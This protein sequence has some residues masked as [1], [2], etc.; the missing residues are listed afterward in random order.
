MQT[1]QATRG[2]SDEIKSASEFAKRQKLEEENRLP[3]VTI[4]SHVQPKKESDTASEWE[5]EL[6]PAIPAKNKLESAGL[7][8]T[9]A[10]TPGKASKW[11]TPMRVSGVGGIAM[12]TPIRSKWD[13]TPAHFEAGNETPL[14][15]HSSA[16][17]P[18]RFTITSTP[19]A[20]ETPNRFSIR[21]GT[22]DSRFD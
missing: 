21:S 2:D 1:L 22:A 4:R 17:T 18:S 6:E 3:T 16:A 14:V 12:E 9:V 15:L 13:K 8:A 10:P 19:V 5:E 20:S 11:D 7:T